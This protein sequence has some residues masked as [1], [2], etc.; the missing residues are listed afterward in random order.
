[1]KKMMLQDAAQASEKEVGMKKIGKKLYPYM[2]ILPALV[3]LCLFTVY[4][5]INQIYLS[6]TSYNLLT[7]PEFIGFENYSNLITD[8]DFMLI[9]WNTILF[10]I[11]SVIVTMILSVSGSSTT[12]AQSVTPASEIE[13][14]YC[15]SGALGD[16]VLKLVDRFN[17]SQDK[18]KVIPVFQGKYD[19]ANGKLQQA[20]VSKKDLC[21]PT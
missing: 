6:M 16:E 1:M 2:L 7:A 4:P 20:L 13:F 21:L 10:T 15:L 8:P 14:W 5:L 3:L 12:A 11:I 18:I 9:L 17:S 19:E